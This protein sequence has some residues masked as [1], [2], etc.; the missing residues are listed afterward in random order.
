LKLIAVRDAQLPPLKYSGTVSHT[1]RPVGNLLF[2][3]LLK[4][5]ANMWSGGCWRFR[6]Q[7]LVAAADGGF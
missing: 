1:A 4:Y 3:R 6:P 2:R 5:F 7:I